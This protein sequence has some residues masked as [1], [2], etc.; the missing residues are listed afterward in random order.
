MAHSWSGVN[1]MSIVD[2]SF[3]SIDFQT[4]SGVSGRSF[5]GMALASDGLLVEEFLD[6]MYFGGDVRGREPRHI[7]D[8]RRS[9]AFQVQQ[10]DLAIGRA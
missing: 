1:V 3:P 10:D 8:L 5:S 4:L 6:A 7:R 9:S 2:C